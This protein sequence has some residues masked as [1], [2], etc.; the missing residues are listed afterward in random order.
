MSVAL[1]S[2]TIDYLSL[3]FLTLNSYARPA[4]R[5]TAQ[6]SPT[7]QFRQKWTISI[8]RGFC[9]FSYA[10]IQVLELV[11]G[12]ETLISLLS[13][14]I[15]DSMSNCRVFWG[16]LSFSFE[17]YF[18]QTNQV[19]TSPLSHGKWVWLYSVALTCK[20]YSWSLDINLRYPKHWMENSCWR[21]ISAP[22]SSNSTAMIPPHPRWMLQCQLHM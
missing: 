5:W 14:N 7:D 9:S 17:N 16:F 2:C 6:P 21:S 22:L 11:T 19:L 8:R 18:V 10:V 3:W 20:R 12:K 15:S 13:S 4:A 1:F